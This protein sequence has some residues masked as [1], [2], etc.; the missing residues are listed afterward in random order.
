MSKLPPNELYILVFDERTN[1][2]S[3]SAYNIRMSFQRRGAVW[4]AWLSD[5]PIKRNYERWKQFV[6]RIES[7][8]D[9]SAIGDTPREA[10]TLLAKVAKA[11]LYRYDTGKKSPAE[12]EV[13]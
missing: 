1:V 8:A 2:Y 7:L 4:I 12:K 10:A 6:E 5:A 9:Y 3:K 11:K 13:A